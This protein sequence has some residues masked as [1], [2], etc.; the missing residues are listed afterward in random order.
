MYVCMFVLI[1]NV[2]IY[3]DHEGFSSLH[4][5]WLRCLPLYLGGAAVP[6]DGLPWQHGGG[7]ST[8]PNEDK[9]A[10]TSEYTI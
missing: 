4:W 2:C 3:L 10:M 9:D 7:R 8:H 6:G 5:P 1:I